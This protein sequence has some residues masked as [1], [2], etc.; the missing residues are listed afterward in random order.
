[1]ASVGLVLNLVC[2]CTTLLC[3]HS[4]GGL[5]FSLHSLPE[6]ANTTAPTQSNC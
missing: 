4:Y 3:L 2:I 5:M 1:M 6:W